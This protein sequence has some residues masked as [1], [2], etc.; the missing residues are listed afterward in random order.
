MVCSVTNHTWLSALQ[1]TRAVARMQKSSD[2]AML[3]NMPAAMALPSSIKASMFSSCEALCLLEIKRR[4][5]FKGSNV[6]EMNLVL[7]LSS[8]RILVGELSRVIY[9]VCVVKIVISSYF[10]LKGLC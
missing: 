9:S 5:L 2:M 3:I 4:V 6:T 8:R 1:L 10:V 7:I